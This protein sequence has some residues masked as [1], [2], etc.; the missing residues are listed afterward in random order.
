MKR[1]SRLAFII[2]ASSLG[3][4]GAVSAALAGYVSQPRR[5]SLAARSKDLEKEGR[6]DKFQSIPSMPYEVKS[7]D[8]YTLHA[9]LLKAEKPS[10]RFVIIS[11]GYGDNHYGAVKYALM[12][13]DLG[14]N[15]ILYDLRGHGENKKA[16]VTLGQKES[17]DLLTLIGDVRMTFGRHVSIGLHGESMGASLSIMALRYRPDIS[18]IVSDCGY[19]DIIKILKDQLRRRFHLPQ[20][21]IRTASLANR[22]MYGYFFGSIRPIRYLKGNEIPIC[23]IHGD[24]DRFIS[25]DQSED[26]YKTTWGYSEI[27]LF[28]GAD[29]AECLLSDEKRYRQVVRD[30]LISIGQL[31][32]QKA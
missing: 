27:H 16:P 17:Q 28:P 5:T 32:D 19:G 20:F 9:Q 21:F 26:M 18:F 3:G 6:W 10:S 25:P 13:H 11:H 31:P 15:C 14:F 29:H 23:F 24:A 12:Y 8:G 4:V 22:I 7:H 30:F 1:S 2:T